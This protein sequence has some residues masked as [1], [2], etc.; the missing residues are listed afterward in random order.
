[1][2]DKVGELYVEITAKID[3][4][5][6]ELDKV[7]KSLEKTGEHTK[8]L[9]EKFRTLGTNLTR[10]GKILTASVTTP[11][12]AIGAASIKSAMDAVESENLFDV[13]FGKMAKTVRE[14]SKQVS[15][16][17]GLNQYEIRK[18]VGI[19]YDMLKAM[20]ITEIQAAE[21]AKQLVML[22]YDLASFR[23]IKP[24]EAF[25]KLRSAIVGMPRPMQDLGYVINETTIKNWALTNGLIKQGEELT[26]AQ[27][28]WARYQV[29]LEVT[30]TAQGDLARTLDSPTNKLRILQSRIEEI[31][32]EI[33]TRLLPQYEKLLAFIN[34]GLD[35][36]DKLSEEQKKATINL[37]KLAAAIGPTL[38]LFGQLVK[39]LPYVK[40]G[41]LD[42]AKPISAVIIGLGLLAAKTKEF[43]NSFA[44]AQDLYRTEEEATGKHISKFT[45]ILSGLEIAWTKVTS[46]LDLNRIAMA[47]MKGQ[48]DA[49][50]RGISF[51]N[52]GLQKF[53]GSFN[54][55]LDLIPKTNKEIGATATLLETE[56]PESMKKADPRIL[57]DGIETLS[58]A[59]STLQTRTLYYA[60]TIDTELP[61][62]FSHNVGMIQKTIDITEVLANVQTELGTR[63]FK[64]TEKIKDAW[65]D[66]SEEIKAV[67][68]RELSNVV[69]EAG[70][71]V[72][73][74]VNI[75]RSMTKI[76]LDVVFK[77][78]VDGMMKAFKKGESF[79]IDAATTMKAGFLAFAAFVTSK[80]IPTILDAFAGLFENIIGKAEYTGDVI[81]KNMLRKVKDG[82]NR[83]AKPILDE[84]E[85]LTKEISDR[86]AGIHF[87]DP[88]RSLNDAWTDLIKKARELGLEGSQAFIDLILKMRELGKESRALSEY[89]LDQ[90]GRIPGALKT[91]IDNVDKSAKRLTALGR[92]GKLAFQ[93]MM[94]EGATFMEALNALKEPLEA[95]RDKYEQLGKE[96]PKFLRP[97][98]DMIGLMEIKPKVFENIDAALTILDS[99]KNTAYLTKDAFNTL[100]QSATSF[101][102]AI[103]NT[104][105]NLN[106]MM[107]TLQLTKTQIEALLPVVAQFVSAAAVFGLP[108]PKWMR[109]FVTE[110]L[111][112]DWNE[113]VKKVSDPAKLTNQWLD[114]SYTR[115][116]K[117]W[118][119]LENHLPKIH[120]TLK[121]I[122]GFQHGGTFTVP[123]PTL[124]TVHPRELIDITPFNKM[125]DRP[126]MPT[127]ASNVNLAFHINALDGA[128]VE[129]VVERRIMPILDKR[130]RD[131]YGGYTRKLSQQTRKY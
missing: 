83:D 66:V 44:K 28:V 98:I 94:A 32:I 7:K 53:A 81:S 97:W 76:L 120:D 29:M 80:L 23:N 15:D 30:K 85:K 13:T 74:I 4:L 110:K 46:G 107:G 122:G 9:D 3:S 50:L 2:A 70:N 18:T 37:G 65:K 90:L 14:W 21:M 99:L 108:V 71:T 61:P 89:I 20:G 92:I 93:A 116:G 26:T 113:F 114:K 64:S 72:D 68:V 39:Y 35:K 45:K 16:A 131:N 52:T 73:K 77:N 31:R 38:I 40:K 8:S 103:L 87:G 56:L 60:R 10:A 55:L 126:T 17:L 125:G 88:G 124:I 102:L 43:M 48:S 112:I 57:V 127:S 105:G 104:S 33:G 11:L 75:F 69:M 109:E 42:L 6:Q 63:V 100:A 86:L 96:V 1:M 129:R 62:A 49:L 25:E 106:K 82:I 123:K 121:R 47:K 41:L 24:E 19:F 91:L 79:A 67:W 111:G 115:L 117:I 84:F 12:L 58:N 54:K 118:N 130:F 101:A 51:V 5:K 36:W 119:S 59:L 128:D 78:L 34:R 95:L 27:K 22:G